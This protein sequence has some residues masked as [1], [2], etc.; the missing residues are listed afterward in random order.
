[1]TGLTPYYGSGSP[2]DRFAAGEA[3][4][5]GYAQLKDL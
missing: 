2:H 3:S 5:I 4:K 1:M